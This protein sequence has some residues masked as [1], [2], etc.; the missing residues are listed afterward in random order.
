[1]HLWELPSGRLRATLRGNTTAVHSVAF[2]PDGKTLAT[3]N[4]AGEVKLWEVATGQERITLRFGWRLA[5]SADG[6]LLAAGSSDGTVRLL[7]AS[8][9]PEALAR[10]S[11]LNPD[12][13]DS[14]LTQNDGADRLWAAGQY[15]EAEAAYR[16]AQ[17]HL[18][19]LLVQ[20]PEVAEFH[21]EICRSGL[22]LKLLLDQRKKH[23]EAERVWQLAEPALRALPP[24]E[25]PVL[26]L[27]VTAV[28]ALLRQS[29]RAEQANRLCLDAADTFARL[30]PDAAAESARRTIVNSLYGNV[31]GLLGGDDQSSEPER[32]YGQWIAALELLTAGRKDEPAAVADL[33]RL[34]QHCRQLVQQHAA[35]KDAQ[36]ALADYQ[37][38]ADFY[39]RLIAEHPHDVDLFNDFDGLRQA[40]A[41][42]LINNEAVEPGEKLL[43]ESLAESLALASERPEYVQAHA[44]RLYNL[45]VAR[46]NAMQPAAA[47]EL[48]QQAYDLHVCLVEQS[49]ADAARRDKF[50]RFRRDLRTAF[51]QV[52]A[53]ERDDETPPQYIPFVLDAITVYERLLAAEPRNVTLRLEY[54]EVLRGVAGL[55]YNANPRRG[56]EAEVVARKGLAVAEAAAKEFPQETAFQW[57]SADL[58]WAVAWSLRHQERHEESVEVFRGAVELRCRLGEQYGATP[59]KRLELHKVWSVLALARYSC[60]KRGESLEARRA[61]LAVA[62]ALAAEAPED[63]ARR[64]ILNGSRRTVAAV[65]AELQHWG[66]AE[67]QLQK[68]EEFYQGRPDDKD[69]AANLAYVWYDRARIYSLRG[70][71]GEAI[72]AYSRAIEL[73]PDIAFIVH[74]RGVAFLNMGEFDQ[75]LSDFTRA[76]ELQ[77]DNPWH[78][79]D[80][81][82]ARVALGQFA[83]AV[84]DL[85]KAIHLREQGGKA[86][87][88]M[89]R[90]RG[91]AYVG[92]GEW[93]LALADFSQALELEPGVSGRWYR[94][95]YLMQLGQFAEGRDY[96]LSVLERIPDSAS[97]LNNLAWLLAT[98]EVPK[99]LDA[100][101]AVELARKAVELAPTEG[102]NWNTLGVA[103][104]RAGDWPAAVESL[105]KSDELG[106]EAVLGFNA[107]FLAMAHWR[108]GH[109]DEARA[110]YDRAVEW[111]DLYLPYNEELCRFQAEAAELLDS[112]SGPHA[113]LSPGSGDG[114]NRAA[115]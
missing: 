42:L 39:R 27:Y 18:Q 74:H 77:P 38:V 103:Q 92:L 109:Q 19:V 10:K 41:M 12:D 105:R 99:F 7:R 47:L 6:Q 54:V 80:G 22:S 44:G 90:A 37:P 108:L 16:Q 106:G 62:E 72:T 14:P 30:P 93:E 81:G 57:W 52:N 46:L 100:P 114:I 13:P 29:G 4:D 33:K 49:P 68:V 69:R 84:A 73:E 71:M 104:Y 82:Y 35:A 85:S 96:Y 5:V 86:E 112:E 75:A 107:F 66:E 53:P 70:Q 98:C 50:R 23:A 55:L 34:G 94:A 45:G 3:A 63:V 67:E 36:A 11:E 97:A 1:V 78:L 32:V 79:A 15:Q 43:D 48:F 8:T 31:L 24:D 21:R 25:Q 28:A 111:T 102:N 76:R 61:A 26:A 59:S 83:E 89:W 64:R 56:A 17:Q 95:Q 51:R 9:A 60:G 20:A 91:E 65:A 110:W 88:W 113:A 40:V 2:F 115:P 87:A 58:M 101:R